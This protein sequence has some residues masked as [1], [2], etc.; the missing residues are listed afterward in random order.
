M[1]ARDQFPRNKRFANVVVG[2]NL[3]PHDAVHIVRTRREHHDRNL[4]VLPNF[5]QHIKAIHVR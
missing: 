3:K 4:R 2:S 1:N 5:P